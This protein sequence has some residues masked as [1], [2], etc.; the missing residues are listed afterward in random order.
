VGEGSVCR[1]AEAADGRGD[2]FHVDL[3]FYNRLLR[4]FML[5][6]LKPGKLTH[7]DLVQMYVND[8]DRTQRAE[9][10]NKT[11]GIVLCSEQDAAMVTITLPEDS[12]QIIA[13]TYRRYLRAMT[14]I[15][16]G[17]ASP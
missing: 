8:D 11:I 4:C 12:D 15:A 6:D 1:P 9:H 10:Q 7:Q 2:H 17:G 16:S 3:L 5:V 13:A 14:A